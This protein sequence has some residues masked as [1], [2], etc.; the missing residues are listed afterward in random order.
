MEFQKKKKTRWK[1]L[2]LKKEIQKKKKISKFL[3]YYIESKQ[4]RQA[5][6][7]N[8]KRVYGKAW[9]PGLGHGR[10]PFYFYFIFIFLPLLSWLF[11][12]YVLGD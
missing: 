8:I 10:R 2:L 6:K 9:E 12:I 4:K 3:C 7:K 11:Y 5:Q 1:S